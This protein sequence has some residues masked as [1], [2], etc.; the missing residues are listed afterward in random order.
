MRALFHIIIGIHACLHLSAEEHVITAVSSYQEPG[1][2]QPQISLL[3][4][5][6]KTLTITWQSSTPAEANKPVEVHRATATRGVLVEKGTA[7]PT[8]EGWTWEWKPPATHGVVHYRI[9]LDGDKEKF[10]KLEVRDPKR[11]GEMRKLI[12]NMTWEASNLERE[13][14]NALAKHGI[15]KSGNSSATSASLTMISNNPIATRRQVIWDSE[16]HD[17]VVWRP[18]TATGDFYIRAPRWWISP[19]ALTT[20][21]GLI[22]LL[23]LFFEAP[24]EP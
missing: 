12:P 20:D 11:I 8:N 22:R 24:I 1:R 23:D 16:N 18:G 19:D 14:L 3:A 4:I 2:P 10:V 17:L 21:Q 6:G 15:R 13:E 5:G 7:S 9:I